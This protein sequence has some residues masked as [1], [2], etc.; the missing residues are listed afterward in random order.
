MELLGKI[1]RQ[2]PMAEQAGVTLFEPHQEQN[3]L[4]FLELI[5]YWMFLKSCKGTKNFESILRFTKAEALMQGNTKFS[6]SKLELE[7]FF[8]LCLLRGVFSKEETT[9]CQVFGKQNMDDHSFVKQCQEISFKLF[10]DI[11]DLTIKFPDRFAEEQTS[12]L[13]FENYGIQ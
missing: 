9:H 4:F 5:R 1:D 12:S 10:L 11:F 6:I 3:N 13:Q 8:G 7:A 2:M